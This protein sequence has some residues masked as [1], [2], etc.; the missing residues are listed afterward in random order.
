MSQEYNLY[1]KR[2]IFL[3]LKPILSC[4][5]LKYWKMD[6]SETCKIVTWLIICTGSK[7]VQIKKNGE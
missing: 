3:F 6:F 5:R 2:N 7:R 4:L 1:K